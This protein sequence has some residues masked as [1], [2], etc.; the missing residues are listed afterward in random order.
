MYKT[1][2]G[3]KNQI[4]FSNQNEYYELLGYLSKSDGTTGLYWEENKEQGAWGN[5]GRIHFYTT[6]TFS[7]LSHTAGTNNIISRVNC[8]EFVKNL[9]ANYNFIYGKTQ[10]KGNIISNI[11]KQYLNDFNRGFLL[12]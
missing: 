12:P 6:R 5:E 3:T 1:K 2:F 10:N 7:Y 4:S 8:N 9:V 11:P